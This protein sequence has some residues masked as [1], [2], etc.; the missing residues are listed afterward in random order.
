[1]G[2]A[3]L[4][5]GI[6]ELRA[7]LAAGYLWLIAAWFLLHD[8]VPTEHEASGLLADAYDLADAV[9]RVGVA[10]AVAFV[11]Y[12]IGSLSLWISASLESV[13]GPV[14]GVS[15]PGRKRIREFVLPV[16]AER[17][18]EAPHRLDSSRD[19]WYPA[20]DFRWVDRIGFRLSEAGRNAL[21]RAVDTTYQALLGHCRAEKLAELF[22]AEDI[23]VNLSDI[24]PAFMQE[25]DEAR[26][27][28]E[29]L[30]TDVEG[31][32]EFIRNM[33]LPLYVY[34]E[35]D[36][37]ELRLLTDSPSLYAAID[38]KRAESEFRLAITPPLFVL[39]IFFSWSWSAWWIFVLPV[40]ALIYADGM[41]RT[42]EAN[43]LDAD[44][45]QLGRVEAPTLERL[46]FAAGIATATAA[47]GREPTSQD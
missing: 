24:V 33:G 14:A 13:G 29:R 34:T 18:P 22:R 10:A 11:A 44:A 9:G 30:Y 31:R 46:K 32:N 15:V 26:S 3:N 16:D 20:Y 39:A 21:Q 4:L 25:A 43:D 35:F 6:R 40:L 19:G 37:I 8:S 41:R 38:R 36:K 45:L 12:L 2:I 27:T 5:P 7:P 1:L 47:V 42:R 28:A 17:Y 23:D